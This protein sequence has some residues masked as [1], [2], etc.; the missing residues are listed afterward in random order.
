MSFGFGKGELQIVMVKKMRNGHTV[1]I[2]TPSDQSGPIASTPMTSGI[3][4][5]NNTSDPQLSS[6]AFSC[7][8]HMS[9]PIQTQSYKGICCSREVW[10]PGMLVQDSATEPL[11]TTTWPSWKP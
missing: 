11:W 9:G 4:L 7:A 2:A 10:D 8:G 1:K 3:P 5:P 6:H